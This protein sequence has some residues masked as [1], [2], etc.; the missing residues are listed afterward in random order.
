MTSE[1]RYNCVLF[2]FLCTCHVPACPRCLALVAEAV[3]EDQDHEGGVVGDDGPGATELSLVLHVEPSAEK[4]NS[5]HTVQ[6]GLHQQKHQVQ[7]CE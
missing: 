7:G 1:K 5:R 4:Q 2:G 3:E 6:G